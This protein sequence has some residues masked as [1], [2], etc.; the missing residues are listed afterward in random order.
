MSN[1]P[2]T[3]A[4]ATRD[5]SRMSGVVVLKFG[6]SVLPTA[7]STFRAAEEIR[8]YRALG[9]RVVAVVSAIGSTTDRL[10]ASAEQLSDQ[11]AS[12]ALVHLLATGETT[13]SAY[14]GLAL[15]ESGETHE[16]LTPLQSGFRAEGSRLEARPASLDAAAIQSAFERS[17]VVIIPGFVAADQAGSPVLLGRGGSDLSAL[18]IAEQLGARAILLKATDGVFEH[19]PFD[20]ERPEPRRFQSLSWQTARSIGG[21]V[22]QDAALELAERSGQL[23]VVR[24]PGSTN[25]TVVGGVAD[26]LEPRRPHPLGVGFS[27]GERETKR[28]IRHEPQPVDAA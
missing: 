28:V 9:Q 15:G 19:D 8:R 14:L 6:S 21:G 13:A 10:L 4:A 2:T 18:Y 25:G 26:R 16:I 17:G 1:E 23:F 12:D 5:P 22:V 11:P 3:S 20:P 7:S 24:T 27:A